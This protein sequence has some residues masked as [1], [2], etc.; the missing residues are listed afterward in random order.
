MNLCMSNTDLTKA[1]LDSNPNDWDTN[2]VP[3]SFTYPGHS[4][5]VE[6]VGDWAPVSAPWEEWSAGDTLQ[7]A[8]YRLFHDDAP[9]DQMDFLA[10]G[11]GR[12]FRCRITLRHQRNR[13]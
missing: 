8:T 5:R 10:L 11:D 2:S 12:C 9:F 13:T 3:D 4:I 1:V 7:Q 6:R